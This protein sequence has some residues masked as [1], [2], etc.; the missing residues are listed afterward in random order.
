[1]TAFTVELGFQVTNPAVDALP[2]D[3]FPVSERKRLLEAHLDDVMVELMDCADIVDP[4]MFTTF[5]KGDVEICVTLKAR[6]RRDAEKKA[7]A[8]IRAAV[9]AAGGFTG[10]WT[11]DWERPKAS[12]VGR[13]LADA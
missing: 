8:L 13:E 5:S 6:T 12:K 7:S 11:I 10:G 3:T 4:T 2:L 1:M 9:H